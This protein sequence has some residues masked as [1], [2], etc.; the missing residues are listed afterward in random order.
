MI[1]DVLVL[2][3]GIVLCIVSVCILLFCINRSVLAVSRQLV[4]IHSQL[5]QAYFV[6]LGINTQLARWE[7]E[8]HKQEERSRFGAY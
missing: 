5:N 7:S 4:D 8:R 1:V 3:L 6:W 2:L